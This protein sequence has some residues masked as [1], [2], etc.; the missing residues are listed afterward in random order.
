MWMVVKETKESRI[1]PN[2]VRKSTE[3]A[4]VEKVWTSS[5]PRCQNARSKEGGPKSRL[6]RASLNILVEY[7]GKI[8]H[9]IYIRHKGI[10]SQQN[11]LQLH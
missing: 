5:T 11:M 7:N 3:K 2:E 10:N 6:L 9:C 8:W 4:A 1:L